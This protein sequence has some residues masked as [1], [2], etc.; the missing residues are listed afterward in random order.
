MTGDG[1]LRLPPD[2]AERIGVSGNQAEFIAGSR[3]WLELFEQH[4]G[5]LFFLALLIAGDAAAAESALVA[6]LDLPDAEM[7]AGHAVGLDEIKWVVAKS[8]VALTRP[9]QDWRNEPSPP[10]PLELQPLLRLDPDLRCCFVLH[11]L[12]KYSHRDCA[13]LLNLEAESVKT[14]VQTALL[15]LSVALSPASDCRTST[16]SRK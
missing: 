10:L 4:I 1:V 12:A 5:N 13:V 9:T 2:P 11:I 8:S 15:S 6:S 7:P 16:S 3:N 14:L